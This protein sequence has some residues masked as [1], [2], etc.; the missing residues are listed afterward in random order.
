[1]VSMDA[2]NQLVF[3]DE[4]DQIVLVKAEFFKHY[5]CFFQRFCVSENAVIARVH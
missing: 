3:L 2:M 4:V 5:S 1:M